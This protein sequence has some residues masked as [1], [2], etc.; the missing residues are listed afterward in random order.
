[1]RHNRLVMA[2]AMIAI[3]S[4]ALAGC[5]SGSAGSSSSASPKTITMWIYPV[6]ADKVA[7]SAY[8]DSTIKAFEAKHEDVT[9][10]Y[11]I[12]PW[13]N[14]DESLGTAIAAGKGPD[15]VYLIPDQLPV[16]AK[17]IEPIESY[18]P[19]EQMDDI[20]PNVANS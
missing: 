15:V 8:W 10:K 5:S 12:F 17:S 14:R 3:A 13:T 6:I 20:L 11:E 1:M 9:V 2:G 18:L 19:K 16:Y 4:T 7:H